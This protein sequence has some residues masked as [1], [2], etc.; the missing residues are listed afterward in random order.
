M[1]PRAALII[2]ALLVATIIGL[3]LHSVRMSR[4]AHCER[5]VAAPYRQLLDRMHQL[6]DAGE[7]EQLR[8]LIARARERSSEIATAC[9][10]PSEDS[11]YAQQVWELTR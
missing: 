10:Q 4:Y 7:S 11:K 3:W 6:A 9:S 8:A 5:G 2:A 1:F